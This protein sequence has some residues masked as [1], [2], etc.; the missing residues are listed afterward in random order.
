L[1]QSVNAAYLGFR[2]IPGQKI[3]SRIHHCGHIEHNR[4]GHFDATVPGD[5]RVH[6]VQHRNSGLE[7][8]GHRNHEGLY[9]MASLGK[10]DRKQNVPDGVHR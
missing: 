2:Q 7:S 8:T 4:I 6:D 1:H 10:I 9:S 3:S 5:W